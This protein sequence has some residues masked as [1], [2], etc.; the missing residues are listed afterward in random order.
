MFVKREREREGEREDEL[1]I[2]L[3][4]LDA[5]YPVLGYRFNQHSLLALNIVIRSHTGFL[6]QAVKSAVQRSAVQCRH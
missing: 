2:P 6:K 3:L 5:L 4:L 1:F